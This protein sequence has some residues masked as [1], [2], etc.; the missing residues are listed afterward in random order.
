QQISFALTDQ[1]P[2]NRLAAAVRSDR[3]TTREGI[4]REVERILKD[5]LRPAEGG[6]HSL[7]RIPRFFEE[8]FG[9]TEA[10]AVFKDEDL[11]R[12]EIRQHLVNDTE[13]LI[14]DI[15]HA[16]RQ[17]LRELLTTQKSY[18]MVDALRSPLFRE[19][20]A[21]GTP[22][23]FGPKNHANEVYNVAVENWK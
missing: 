11:L 3:L 2:D 10:P 5:G 12:P 19:A 13:R 1:Q 22:H 18:V 23:P 7:V 4:R 9:Y 15:L 16:D 8:Y 21:K 20:K 6:R 14:N 17:V